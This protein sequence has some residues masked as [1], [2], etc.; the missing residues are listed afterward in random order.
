[1]VLK[2]FEAFAGYGGA[3]FALKKAGINF[4]CVGY[5]EIDKYAI[6]CYW[7][8]HKGKYLG[9]ITKIDPNKLPDFDLFT[10]GFPCQSFSIAGKGNGELDA[11]GTLFYEII[12]ICE[13]KKPKYIVLENV[14]GLTCKNHKA[15][16]EKI[17]N[18]LKRIGYNVRWRI[19]NTKNYGVPQNRERVF[20][21]CY[22]QD[23]PEGFDFEFPEEE[24]LKIFLKDILE[25]GV[26]EKYYLNEEQTKRLL[27]N[28]N[29]AKFK[30]S[31]DLTYISSV[32]KHNTVRDDGIS[33]AL[34]SAMGMGGGHTP[35]IIQLNKPKHSNNRVYDVNGISPTLNTMQSGHRQPFIAIK[36]ATK[37][38]YLE[39]YPGDGV[40]LEHPDSKTRRGRIQ[41]DVM[42]CLQTNDQR[43]VITEDY[44][45]R[46]LTPKECFR[47]MGFLNDE[48]NL[49]GLSN[50]QKYKLAG[51]GWDINL[52]SKIFR[53]MFKD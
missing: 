41:K 42:G 33:N 7:K 51:N 53:R 50:T 18:E 49:D 48:I 22:R 4:E 26:D 29:V 3:S 2:I 17:L 1:M 46:K 31:K 36:N 14:K 24:E 35:M 12:R 28:P 8:N 43:G 27:L 13:V 45:I 19:L 39:G 9:D 6:E 5:S 47:L 38:G 30:I 15:T 40:N 11:R 25:E 21:Y 37:K 52:V 44:R 16:F 32:Q 34:P 20:F 10:G 23:Y